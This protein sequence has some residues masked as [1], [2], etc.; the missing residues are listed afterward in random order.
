MSSEPKTI[1]R[2]APVRVCG[3]PT[4][5]EARARIHFRGT[6]IL[7]DQQVRLHPTG[8]VVAQL[9]VAVGQGHGG[10]V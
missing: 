1:D 10:R 5:A 2:S 6:R 4:V 8:T 9:A 7:D 3:S